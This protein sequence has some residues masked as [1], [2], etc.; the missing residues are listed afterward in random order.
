MTELIKDGSTMQWSPKAQFSFE[1]LKKAFCEASLL[2]QFHSR[3]LIFI[4]T[5]ASNFTLSDILSQK[6]EN[7]HKHSIVFFSHKLTGAECNYETSDHKLL[8]IVAS[9]KAW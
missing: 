1:C 3:D 5:N 8:T 9:F 7:R 4:E 2:G 6:N